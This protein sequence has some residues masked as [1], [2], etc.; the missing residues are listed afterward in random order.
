[1]YEFVA[2]VR[3][4]KLVVDGI[5]FQNQSTGGISRIYHEILPLMCTL[6]EKM[7]ITILTS[8]RLRQ[9]MPE[10]PRIFHTRILPVSDVLRPRRIWLRPHESIRRRLISRAIADVEDDAV[11]LSTYYTMPPT[12]W[13]GKTVAFV[14]DMIHEKYAHL[15][16]KYTGTLF[17]GQK[18]RVVESADRVICISET[19]RQ[20]VLGLYQLNPDHVGV[21]HLAHSPVFRPLA[22]EIK[23]PFPQPYILYVGSRV[24]YKNFRFLL[25]GF[26]NWPN[27][28][29]DLV[30]VGSPWTEAENELL[31]KYGLVGRVHLLSGVSDGELNTLYNAAK[32]FVYPSLYEG[33]GIPLLEAMA[34]GC[35]VVASDIPSSREV[36]VEFAYYF[37]AVSVNSLQMALDRAICNGRQTAQVQQAL[38]YVQQFSWMSTLYQMTP[39][40]I[41]V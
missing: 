36:A 26:A 11:W 25:E 20:D 29:I 22:G 35:P 28:Q 23:S 18:R 1:L 33:F 10:H 31:Q 9:P 24:H 2:L 7:K 4:M 8:G 12:G 5:I 40:I 3:E 27:R 16:N 32:A 19:T 39:L 15:F 21:A 13:T 38:S 34:C 17:R 6:D 14:Y 41:S 30:V 37:D